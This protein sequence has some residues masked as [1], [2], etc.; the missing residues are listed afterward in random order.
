MTKEELLNRIRAVFQDV[1]REDGI[2]LREG[3]VCDDYGNDDAKA[4]AR[5]LDK[6]QHWSEIPD[7]DL[8]KYTVSLSYFD[9]KSYKYY[10]PA[11]M[12]FVLNNFYK[13]PGAFCHDAIIYS[14]DIYNSYH[15]N[16]VS[17][18]T[19]A[20]CEVVALFVKYYIDV[21]GDD[22]DLEAAQLAMENHWEQYLLPL[23]EGA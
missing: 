6:D 23:K 19:R 8:I 18:L 5:L 4:E 13:I 14:L 7:D 21:F 17:L 9:E 12:I 22:G 11:Y 15:L 16:Q 2:S 3:K 10:L 1:S 20:Q